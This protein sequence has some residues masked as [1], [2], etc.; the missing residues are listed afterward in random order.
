[1]IKGTA[2]VITPLYAPMHVTILRLLQ[3]DL[4][5]RF[6]VCNELEQACR[7]FSLLCDCNLCNFITYMPYQFEFHQFIQTASVYMNGRLLFLC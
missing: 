7:T 2:K 1:M 5:S 6:C 4:H 3:Y